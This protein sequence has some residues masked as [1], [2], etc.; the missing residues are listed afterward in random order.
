M[1]FRI[2]KIIQTIEESSFVEF[3]SI[4]QYQS[5]QLSLSVYFSL[6]ISISVQL[7]VAQDYS[8]RTTRSIHCEM[9]NTF[10]VI[11][12]NTVF[13]PTSYPCS[14]KLKHQSHTGF[15]GQIHSLLLDLVERNSTSK[16]LFCAQEITLSKDRIYDQAAP[17]E[18]V[19][20]NE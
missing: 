3:I 14:T 11:H 15:H 5:E 19:V 7:H 10:R 18:P 13:I 16:L 6:K 4:S 8:S 1:F 9:T 20:V 12:S 17:Q 2:I